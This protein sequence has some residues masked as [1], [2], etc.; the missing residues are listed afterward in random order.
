MDATAITQT[1]K[2][3]HRNLY[4]D[5]AWWAVL[6]GSTLSFLPIFMARLNATS[7]QIGLLTAGPAVIN[8]IVSL[9]AGRWLQ[10]RRLSKVTFYTAFAHRLVY[11][12]LIVLIWYLSPKTL[13]W[14]ILVM[15]LIAA[16]PGALVEI[17]FNA[18]FADLVTPK[19][20]AQVVGRRNALLALSMSTTSLLCG[21]FL[22]VFPFPDGYQIVFLLG[23]FGAVLSTY[24]LSRLKDTPPPTERIGQPI[25][26]MARSGLAMIGDAIRKPTGLRYLLRT[27]GQKALRLD[28]L[29]TPFG[30]LVA[31]YFAFYC[32]HYLILPLS[33][34]FEVQN[35]GLSDAVISLGLTLFY[36]TMFIS[37]L[38]FPRFTDWAKE[39]TL[40]I[41]VVAACSWPLLLVIS[42][43]APVPLFLLASLISG[44]SWGINNGSLVKTL[45]DR[46]PTEDRPA[47]MALHHIALNFG[48]LAGSLTGPLVAE[49]L[50]IAQTILLGAVLRLGVALLF[51][52]QR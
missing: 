5:A 39:N 16:L 33:S 42:L 49:F 31:T 27:G 28:L 34:L 41:S 52:K 9:P 20:R 36:L 4:A 12:L 26:G 21:Y 51:R 17:G 23:T 40:W 45:M 8:L 22:N 43:A 50:G 7:F 37:S 1:Q 30:P 15:I 14:A 11:P 32:T 48:I 35:L 13:I 19:W 29:K 25:M 10:N 3:N 46:V 24:Y 2:A 44:S 38:A 6:S 18:L 47:H